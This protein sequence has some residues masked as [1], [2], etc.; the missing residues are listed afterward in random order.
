MFHRNISVLQCAI[1]TTKLLS[2]AVPRVWERLEYRLDSTNI[3]VLDN[4][5]DTQCIVGQDPGGQSTAEVRSYD[6]TVTASF[7]LSMFFKNIVSSPA[8]LSR[9]P[10][11]FLVCSC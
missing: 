1:D 11:A 10:H 7:R 8:L 6:S 5:Q 3:F 4:R 2:L 9:H